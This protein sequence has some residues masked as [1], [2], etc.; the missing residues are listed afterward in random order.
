MYLFAGKRR[1]SDVASFL[2]QAHDEGRINLTLEEYDLELSPDHDLTDLSIWEDI[3]ATLAEGGWTLIVSPPCNTFSRARF[4]FQEWPGPR[5]LRNFNCPRGFPWLSQHHRAVVEEANLFVDRCIK[6]CLVC[7]SAGGKF[8]IEHPEDLGLVKDERPGSIWQWTEILDL[9]PTCG[10]ITFAIQ[11]CHFGALTPK[12]TRF[13]GTLATDDKRCHAGLPRFD[14]IGAYRGPLPKSC[15]HVHKHKLLGKTA[16]KWNTS[17]S[18]SYPPGLCEFLAGLVLNAA[19]S[20]G[21]GSKN[22]QD[23]GQTFSADNTTSDTAE[24]TTPG[25]SSSRGGAKASVGGGSSSV[26]GSSSLVTA[27]DP[28]CGGSSSTTTPGLTAEKSSTADD[29]V[30]VDL[31]VNENEEADEFDMERCCNY[32]S[33]IKVEWDGKVHDFI[34]GFGL[35]SPTRWHPRARGHKRCLKMKQLASQTFQCLQD[36]VSE[37]LQDV[38]L[39]A[40]KLV[41]GK[42]QSSPFTEELLMKVRTRI[43]ALLR[44]PEDAMTK[45]TGQPFY[46]RLL[47]QWLEVY[48]DPDVDCLVSNSDS[49]ATGVNVGVEDPLP[50]S[51]QIFPPKVKHRRLD[52]TEFNPIADNYVSGQLSAKELE[53]K[54]REEEA[55][56]RMEPSK[57][58]VL[59][60]RFGDKLRVAAMAAIVKPDGGVRPLHDATHSVMVNHAITY[61]DQ[62]QCPGPAEVATVVR[63]AVE[64]REAP[65]CVSADIR[66]AHRLVKIREAD[67]PYICCR[68]DS[69]SETVWINK[70]GTFGVSSAPYWWSKLFAAVGRFVGHVL[71]SSVF[72]HMVYVDD[73]HGAFT[74]ERKFVCLWIWLLAFEVIG[75]PFGYHKFKGGFSS[76]FVGF[77]LRYDRCEVGITTKRGTWLIDWIKALEGK[78]FVVPA[79][80]FSEFLGRLSFVAQLLTWLKP[81]LAP[82]F[83]WGSVASPGLVGRLPDTVIL[84]LKYIL[85]E[86]S[87]ESFLVSARRPVYFETEQFRTDAKCADDYIVLGGWELKSKRWFSLRLTRKEV[88]YLFKPCGGGSQWAS[89]SA[90]LLASLTALHAFGWLSVASTRRT[91][92]LSLCGGTDNLA[93]DSLSTKRSTTKWPLMLINMQLS[94]ALSKARLNLRLRWRPREENVEA[95]QLTNEIFEGFSPSLRVPLSFEDVDVRLVEELWETKLQFDAARQESKDSK[96]VADGS[97]KRKFE[98]SEW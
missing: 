30:V 57:M 48:Q 68:S 8:I 98:K 55:L 28:T 32:G 20:F 14:K 1:Q 49:F 24:F 79:R 72:W 58:A 25:G 95:D 76:D 16:N 52:D 80:E 97:K 18:A 51:P 60:A 67:W 62:L 65:F 29:A 38:R 54:F 11:Q 2:Q 3:W 70:T 5:P 23:K 4:H 56:G 26:G 6:A 17:P 33:P 73:L 69:N 45:D 77:H 12:P 39:D 75:T 53:E 9:I 44:D 86:L 7:H 22:Q 90:E 74:G 66:A 27:K 78:K 37:A 46:L 47:A 93:N 43:A 10:A 31:T 91:M 50:R 89:T 40:F 21:R 87:S 84:T 94:A 15:G 19:H 13:L 81:H 59:K 92:A 83:A 35:C 82:L 71:Q 34:D 41:T 63:E 88:P 61:R 96:K 85:G 64:S 36:G 42:L